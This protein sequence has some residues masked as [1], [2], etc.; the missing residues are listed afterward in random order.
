[1][2]N[3]LLKKRKK[4]IINLETEDIFGNGSNED[5]LTLLETAILVKNILSQECDEET[6]ERI[7]KHLLDGAKNEKSR[8]ILEEYILNRE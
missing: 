1:M 5:R 8:R 7:S 2:I 3:K 4:M 6:K